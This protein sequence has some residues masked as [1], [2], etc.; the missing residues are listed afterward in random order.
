VIVEYLIAVHAGREFLSAVEADRIIEPVI[1][2]IIVE[3]I[4]TLLA[5]SPL[6]LH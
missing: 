1:K 4:L 5:V 2:A 3:V 6:I